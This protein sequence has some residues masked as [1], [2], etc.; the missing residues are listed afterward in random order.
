M[1]RISNIIIGCIIGV[2]ILMYIFIWAFKYEDKATGYQYREEYR[3][4][5]RDQ[6]RL[7]AIKAGVANIDNGVFAWKTNAASV[8]LNE[9]EEVV[10]GILVEL[11]KRK[12][13]H[14]EVIQEKE[15]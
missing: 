3:E 15:K 5:G 9:L 1:S 11:N 10:K 6:V 8:S 2:V 7:E 14:E 13:I 4:Q 12:G